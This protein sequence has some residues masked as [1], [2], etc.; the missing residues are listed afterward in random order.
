MHSHIDSAQHEQ[1]SVLCSNSSGEIRACPGCGDME[2]TFGNVVIGLA[3]SDIPV[4]LRRIIELQ[5]T[6]PNQGV[7]VLY[8]N[9]AGLGVRFDREQLRELRELLES[10]QS[11][12]A[13]AVM[14]AICGASP[15]SG[16]LVH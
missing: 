2:L 9:D 16:S 7:A 13:S 1:P 10:A 14:G 15:A 3:R 4:F 6:S 8:L 11:Y 12:G 5:G